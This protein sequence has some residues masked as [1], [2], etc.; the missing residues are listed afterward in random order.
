M[1][2]LARLRLATVRLASWS[3]HERTSDTSLTEHIVFVFYS[4]FKELLRRYCLTDL[5]GYMDLTN[6]ATVLCTSIC[7]LLIAGHFFGIRLFVSSSI[8]AFGFFII[9]SLFRWSSQVD[10]E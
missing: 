7:H 6:V 3:K 8:F 2:I 9:C 4:S 5:T 1:P 10:A